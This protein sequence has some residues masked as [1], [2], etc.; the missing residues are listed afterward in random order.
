VN[1]VVP[2]ERFAEEV[3]ALAAR[4][5]AAP[6]RPVSEIKQLLF[7]SCRE[8]LERALEYEILRQAECFQSEDSLE[9]INAFF[10]KR[11]PNFR[12]R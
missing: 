7:G 3:R 5:A 1:H 12:R 6:P 10:E 9:G 2:A 11:K 8:E 4:L